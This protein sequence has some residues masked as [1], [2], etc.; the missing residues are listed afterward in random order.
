M[1]AAS[2]VARSKASLNPDASKRKYNAGITEQ[3]G[4]WMPAAD[5]FEP[6]PASAD[7]FLTFYESSEGRRRSF[8]GRCGTNLAYTIFPILEGWPVILDIVL[9][10][11]DRQDLEDEALAPERQLWWKSGIPWVQQL[12]VGGYAMAPKHPVYKINE[13][14]E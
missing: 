7:S 14:V 6:G 1:V 2:L 9:G 3:H 8:C 4:D 5:I 13:F 11:I 10:T 12:S